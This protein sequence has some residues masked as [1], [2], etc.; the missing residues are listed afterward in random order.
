MAGVDL[1]F[2]GGDILTMAGSAPPAR[3]LAVDAGRIVYV[4]D[5][6]PEA[7][8]ANAREVVDLAGRA[9]MPG[10][11]DAHV[12][13]GLT[14]AL[15]RGVEL[16]QVGTLDALGDLV[17]TW[18]RYEP[19]ASPILGRGLRAAAFAS[20]RL[21]DRADLDR[22]EPEVPLL[23]VRWDARAAVVNTP[24]M[25]E[26]ALPAA[27]PGFVGG[28][29]LD[30]KT[31]LLVGEALWSAL[32]GVS[33]MLSPGELVRGLAQVA[34]AA[35][36]R[37]VTTLHCMEGVGFQRGRETRALLG[38][39]TSL[40]LHLLPYHRSAEV[41]HRELGGF[42]AAVL[43][44]PPGSDDTLPV[45]VASRA[46]DHAALDRVVARA[47]RR[48]FQVAIGATGPGAVE[49]ALRAFEAALAVAPQ[50]DH[51][52]RIDGCGAL[53]D[54]QLRRMG[55]LGL[56]AVLRVAPGGGPV[57]AAARRL[58]DRG[59]LVAAG[60]GAPVGPIDPLGVAVAL[61]RPQGEGLTLAE[62]LATVTVD[63]AR[64]G[65]AEGETGTLT[66]GKRADLVMLS[67]S[68]HA[69]G[70]EGLRILQV[71]VGGQRMV[72]QPASMLRFAWCSLRG[73]LRSAVGLR[74]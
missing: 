58:V 21:P 72:A 67:A 6:T 19:D 66:P 52:H 64:A 39:Q 73:R 63:A 50:V 45:E 51:R 69:A 26:L 7:L 68:P 30:E 47:H 12:Q 3:T 8:R 24:M 65:L 25:L 2:T 11:H 31:G 27:T 37:G 46:V 62:A 70:M 1:L 35:L 34:N 48:G 42:L 38:L 43:D 23:L 28:P 14:A 4:G 15:A 18:R 56:T 55:E 57:A 61:T 41:R 33:R 20:G 44:G 74:P 9:L 10:F 36:D 5:R 60:S 17:R 54:D 29:T 32:D 59:I 53:N 71:W 22:V 13:L 49:A 16:G 40:R